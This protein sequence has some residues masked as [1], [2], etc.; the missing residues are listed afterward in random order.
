MSPRLS[1]GL[2]PQHRGTSLLHNP[3]RRKKTGV[4]IASNAFKFPLGV[5]CLTS[6]CTT[7]RVQDEL[8]WWYGPKAGHV[9]GRFRKSL[10]GRGR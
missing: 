4:K 10:K 9:D 2:H 6:S 8:K 5:L 1:E 7:V 3:N